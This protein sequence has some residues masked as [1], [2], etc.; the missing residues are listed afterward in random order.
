MTDNDTFSCQFFTPDGTKMYYTIHVGTNVFTESI[1]FAAAALANGLTH[2]APGLNAGENLDTITTVMRRA[3]SDGTPIIDFYTDWGFAKGDNKP[4]GTYKFLHVYLNEDQPE[5]TSEFLAASGFKSLEDIPLY[6]GQ[7]SLVRTEGKRHQKETAVP[8]PFKI[9][10]E[11]GE[12][13][14][15]SD[16]K[17]YRP[18]KLVRYESIGSSN[19]IQD[20]PKNEPQG[21]KAPSAPLSSIDDKDTAWNTVKSKVEE[22]C[23][24]VSTYFAQQ[25][26]KVKGDDIFGAINIVTQQSASRWSELTNITQADAWASILLQ[27]SNM[28]KA[29]ALAQIKGDPVLTRAIEFWASPSGTIDF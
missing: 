21:A 27:T 19:I 24:I 6:D 2:E 5:M 13:K 28:D 22:F 12:E 29:K 18:W 9:I 8:T 25:R 14:I 15:G 11:Q 1:A 4:W 7:S 23:Y 17:P 10:K 16:G 3:K 26:V 20:T